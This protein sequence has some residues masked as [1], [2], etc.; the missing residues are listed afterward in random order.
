MKYSLPRAA[1]LVCAA[2]ALAASAAPVNTAKGQ[3]ERERIER[4]GAAVEFFD[5]PAVGRRHGVLEGEFADVRFRISDAASGRPLRG[6]KPGAWMDMAQVTEGRGAE[7]KS[8]KDK[9]SLYLKGA[10]GIRP[11]VDLNSYF[12]VLMNNDASLAVVDPVVSMGGTTST[13]GSIVLKAPGGDWAAATSQRRLF[14]SLPRADALAIVDTD[15]FKVIDTIDAGKTPLRV[16]L[17]PDGRY[18][19]V[20]NNAAEAAASGATVIDA[21]S[22]KAWASSPRAPVTMSSRSRPTVGARSS[23]TARRHR[24]RDRHRVAQAVVDHHGGQAAAGARPLDAVARALR[25]RRPG[26]PGHGGR[27]RNPA[28]AHARRAAS[29][30][31]A[32]CASRPTGGMRWCST[33]AKTWCT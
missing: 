28:R 26:R 9:I 12:V 23:A 22:G 33:R 15:A 13:L 19:W 2:A 30:A 14:V 11:M 7:Q 21:Q 27:C 24:E 16:A 10:V 1:A 18:L 29:P 17:Q 5:R 4:N 3:A 6:A 20:G 31:S 8:C 25:G 32:R